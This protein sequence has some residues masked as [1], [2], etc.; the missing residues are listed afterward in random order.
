ML[1]RI[2][3]KRTR[4]HIKQRYSPLNPPSAITVRVEL[5][6]RSCYVYRTDRCITGFVVD[7]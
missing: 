4:S 5:W 7:I 3:S 1:R 6:L 2:L